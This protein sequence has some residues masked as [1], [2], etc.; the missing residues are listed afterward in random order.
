MCGRYYLKTPPAQLAVHFELETIDYKPEPN[1]NVSPTQ[2]VPV[3]LSDSPKTLSDAKWGLIPSWAKDGKIGSSLINA[4]AEGIEEKP[5]FRSA[6]KRRRC[7][8]L[9]DGFYEWRKNP[10]GTKTP[11][12]YSLKSGEPFAFAGLWEVWRPLNGDSLRTC[13]IITTDANETVTPVHNRMPV[14]LPRGEENTWLDVEGTSTG[15]AISLL[16]PFPADL[17]TG[18]EVSQGP[19]ITIS[20]ARK[21]A[22]TT[23]S[24]F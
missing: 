4:R 16:R 18:L 13:T 23:A 7:L 6:F 2:I 24:L 12:Q 17:M 3:V 11:I 5:S 9:A 20:K 22:N 15:E 14:I 1:E 19:L 10:D 21:T 8:V